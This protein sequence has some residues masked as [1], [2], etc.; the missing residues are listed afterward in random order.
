MSTSME[1]ALAKAQ[2][3]IAEL[4]MDAAGKKAHAEKALTRSELDELRKRDPKA[5]HDAVVVQ[6][7]RIIDDP[8]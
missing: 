3:K 2:Q 6:K 8:V 5:A 4:T 7:R 1:E